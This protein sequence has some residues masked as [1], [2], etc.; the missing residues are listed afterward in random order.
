[1]QRNAIWLAFVIIVLGFSV[2]FIVKAGYDLARYYQ[3]NTEVPI[4]IEKWEVIEKQANKYAVEV[5]YTYEYEGK[6][7]QGEGQLGDDYPNPWAASRAVERMKQEKWGVWIRS[8]IP[9]KGLLRRK[10]PYKAALSAVVLIGLV[11]YF[12]ILGLYAGV[13]NEKRRP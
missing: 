13:K 11:I 9:D 5:A 2:W 7:Y 4:A 12:I 10:F 8:S 3:F 6:D 1:M